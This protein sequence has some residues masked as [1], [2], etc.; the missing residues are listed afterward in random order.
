MVPVS[1]TKLLVVLTAIFASGIARPSIWSI[2]EISAPT[3]ISAEKTTLP[4]ALVA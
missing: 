3:A 2:E 4:E 1:S